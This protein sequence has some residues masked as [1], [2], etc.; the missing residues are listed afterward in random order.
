MATRDSILSEVILRIQDTS[1]ETWTEVELKNYIDTALEG[2]YPNYYIR[3]IETTTAVVGP[4]QTKPTGCKNLHQIAHKRTTSNRARNVRRWTEGITKAMIPRTNILGDTLIWS[5][6]EGWD[7]PDNDSDLIVDLPLEATEAVVLRT[8]ITAIERILAEKE[9]LNKYLAIQ[10][11]EEVSENDI[12]LTLD[13]FHAQL[14]KKL[15]VAHPLPE[16]KARR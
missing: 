10:A 1:Y 6:T 16:L 2:L 5:W 15:E 8:C 13:A 12:A 7:A 4:L 14:D 3:R 9:R 11:R